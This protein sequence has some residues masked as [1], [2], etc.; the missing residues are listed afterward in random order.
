MKFKVLI[1][2]DEISLCKLMQLKLES[3]G[4]EVNYAL[5]GVAGLRLVYEL[6]PDIVILDLIMPGMDGYEVCKRLRQ[7]SDVP[8]LM[9]TAKGNE[10]DIVQGFECGTNDYLKKPFGFDELTARI[11]ALVGRRK[12]SHEPASRYKDDYLEINLNRKIVIVNSERVHLSSKEY[13]LLS[14]LFQNQGKVIPHLILLNEIWGSS[15]SDART[16][17]NLY[18]YYLRKKIEKNPA[19]PEYIQT[20][21]GIGYYFSPKHESSNAQRSQY[22]QPI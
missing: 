13:R 12:E 21:W 4:F 8:I 9:L 17:L 11:L 22:V 6:R 19:K 10:K 18:I 5:D 2:D 7:I 20:E 14:Y 3:K 1:I 16:S 15:Y